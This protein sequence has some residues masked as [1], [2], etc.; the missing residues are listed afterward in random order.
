MKISFF[1]KNASRSQNTVNFKK[2]IKKSMEIEKV[3]KEW[4]ES[5]GS[6]LHLAV[7]PDLSLPP[8]D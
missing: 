7:N 8:L 2:A 1:L 3:E 6:L 5:L 4:V